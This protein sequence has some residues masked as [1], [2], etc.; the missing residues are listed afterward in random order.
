M[1]T[2]YMTFCLMIVFFIRL[3]ELYWRISNKNQLELI[4]KNQFCMRKDMV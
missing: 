1:Y 4:L 2:E 3:E